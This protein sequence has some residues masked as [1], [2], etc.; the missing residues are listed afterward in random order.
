[1]IKKGPHKTLTWRNGVDN[2]KGFTGARGGKFNI[3]LKIFSGKL[4]SK[5]EF[6]RDFFFKKEF[7][8]LLR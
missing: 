6:L 5:K 8:L 2:V 1:M 3:F 4:S 7:L